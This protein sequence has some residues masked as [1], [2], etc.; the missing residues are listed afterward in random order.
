MSVLLRTGLPAVAVGF[1]QRHVRPDRGEHLFHA[2]EL[3]F[4]L[5]AD[6]SRHGGSTSSV[7]QLPLDLE[8]ASFDLLQSTF[9]LDDL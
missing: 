6:P 3:S 5:G 8:Q 7:E 1:V 2:Q 4:D 9:C